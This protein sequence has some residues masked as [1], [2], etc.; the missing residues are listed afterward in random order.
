[1]HV[2]LWGKELG[3]NSE[4]SILRKN[5]IKMLLFLGSLN[6]LVKFPFNRTIKFNVEY[7]RNSRI[8]TEKNVEKMNFKSKYVLNVFKF[9]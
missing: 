6:S 7:L 3:R 4:I 1:M 2:L 5:F 9:F 8:R